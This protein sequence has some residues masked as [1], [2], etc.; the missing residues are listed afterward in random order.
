MVTKR[1]CNARMSDGVLAL[2][3]TTRT[4]AEFIAVTRLML[5]FSS[6]SVRTR[7]VVSLAH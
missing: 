4:L 1:P 5:R 2:L 7:E 6:H 3:V